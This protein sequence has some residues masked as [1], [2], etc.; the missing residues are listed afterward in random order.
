MNG[1]SRKPNMLHGVELGYGES[2]NPS[3]GG[4]LKKDQGLEPV[5]R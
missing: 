5:W 4:N 1:R 2:P 3:A